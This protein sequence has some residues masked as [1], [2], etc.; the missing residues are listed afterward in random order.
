MNKYQITKFNFLPFV[1][2][3]LLFVI[4]FVSC[5]LFTGS[6]VDLYNVISDEVDWANAP[7]LEVRIEYPSAWGVSSPAQGGITPVMDIRKGYEFKVEFT[8]DLMYYT[9]KSWMVFRT[10][11]LKRI[12]VPASWV[13][14]PDIIKD[15]NIIQ[16]LKEDE[17]TLRDFNPADKVFYFTLNTADPVTLVPCCD[18]EPRITR[19]E[20]RHRPDGQPYSRDS[21]IVLYFNGALDEDTVKFA[22]S[23]TGAGI[24][25]TAAD[26]NNV[27]SVT[28][29][30][31]EKWFSDPEYSAVGGFFKV[32]MKTVDNF[33]PPE[34]LM[35]VTVRGIL[36]SQGN[37][38]ADA[39]YS[40][41][42]KT[43]RA[44]NV[45]LNSYSADYKEEENKIGISFN[46]TGADKVVIYY[47]LNGGA[48]SPLV[49]IEK[50]DLSFMLPQSIGN[51]SKLDDS[52]VREGRQTKGI[53]EYEIF[54]ELY[55]EEIIGSRTSFKIW[56][57]PG[58]IT[59]D[60]NPLVEVT[61]A[62][63]LAVMETNDSD[64]N[65][66][67]ANDIEISTEW[68][69]IG[70]SDK[71][72][73]GNFYANGHTITFTGCIGGDG[74]YRGLFGY[75]QNAVIR[76]LTLNYNASVIDVVTGDF[77]DADWEKNIFYNI[78]GIA[79]YLKDTTVRN[80]ITS[81]E[82]FEINGQAGNEY[83]RLGG[84]A[85][86]IEGSGKIENCRAAL[87]P[88][89]T[90]NEQKSEF[91]PGRTLV[92]GAVVG[93]T[94]TGNGESITLDNGY[95]YPKP[96]LNGL[97]LNEVTIAADVDAQMN[98]SSGYLYIGGAVGKSGQNT[99][100]NISF[101]AG[102]A[103]SST[104]TAGPNSCGGIVGRCGT[105]NIL[106]CR[107]TGNITVSDVYNN[108]V[109]MGGLVGCFNNNPDGKY[110]INKCQVWGNIKLSSN[111]DKFV[112]GVLGYSLNEGEMTITNC[113]FDGGE[114]SV[115]GPLGTTVG[116]FLVRSS[117][118]NNINN[119]GTF[120][121]IITVNS[122]ILIDVGG[123][124]A[125]FTGSISNCFSM[126]DI[127]TTGSCHQS[128][129]G[130]CGK[131]NNSSTINACYATGTVSSIIDGYYQIQIGGLVGYSGGTINNCYA[132]GNVLADKKSGNGYYVY[133]GGLVG[134]TYGN[135]NI[136]NC[137]ST[138]QVSAQSASDSEPDVVYVYVG[139]IVGN[140]STGTGT[141]YNTAVLG[142]S[143]TALG[144]GTK[145]V[146][147][148]FGKN[149]DTSSN[150]YALNTMVIEDDEYNKPDPSTR[151]ASSSA[152]GRDGEGVASV[153]FFTPSFW[154]G[155][156]SFSSNVWDFSRVAKDGH[157][158]LL[159]VGGQ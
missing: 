34:S 62:D 99:M 139:G 150:N 83:I 135:L 109:Y 6:K 149:S 94:G 74:K 75:T 155:K 137:F 128:V 77:V 121:G 18:T 9:L 80:V 66:V 145:N 152:A 57:I 37:S 61:T 112:G 30:K 21:S 88:I 96:L 33:P 29:N 65:Y 32:T 90:S 44:V 125:E 130:F 157:P 100:K 158:R 8:P 55:E 73:K 111:F 70:D 134:Y 127:I 60:T 133:T 154:S 115:E 52:G 151:P 50:N 22:D 11:D 42:W 54:I 113:F 63:Q 86:Y 143:V 58:M 119:C 91:K 87:K 138:G 20:P 79:G 14:N 153:V 64:V 101:T 93:E 76:D 49:T 98:S 7:K 89:F 38:M 10:E 81:G 110:Y 114:I 108:T 40:F 25:I 105:T 122:N 118:T 17:V 141:I 126:I 41:S 136:T 97:L 78:G 47:R 159:N 36:N 12:S 35:T 92:I 144:S 124:A 131:L 43:Q 148:I 107:F 72:F 5:D 147:R 2:C 28:D 102:R 95:T 59:S 146:G 15:L 39:G 67:L 82:K 69:P 31:K 3:S 140:K 26:L 132:M 56:N 51:V 46:Q 129:G 4:C 116:G 24:R 27:N 85:G 104:G 117:G 48:D 120:S 103:V 123:F 142:A 53:S 19:T 68:I 106:E 13:E 45:K 71:P 1:L 16:P 156:L 84:I 23:E